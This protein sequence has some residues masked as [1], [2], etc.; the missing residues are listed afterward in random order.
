MEQEGQ[1]RNLVQARVQAGAQAGTYI[2]A[3]VGNCSESQTISVCF[4]HLVLGESKV[5]AHILCEW[6]LGFSQTCCQ[7]HWFSNQLSG[8]ALPVL[9][10]R[11][12]VL[13]M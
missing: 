1:G 10:P 8:L 5:C 11:A 12:E 6:S 9:D 13:N 3:V 2:E 7:S 4:L